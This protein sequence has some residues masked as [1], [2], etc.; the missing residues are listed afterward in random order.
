MRKIKN[1]SVQKEQ[2]EAKVR[3][4][5]V[6]INYL[7]ERISSL[8]KDQQVLDNQGLDLTSHT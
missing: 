3:D 7:E 2:L 6:Q 5:Q 1:L 8:S 4:Y